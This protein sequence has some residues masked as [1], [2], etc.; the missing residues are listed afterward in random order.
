MFVIIGVAMSVPVL[1]DHNTW[2]NALECSLV[3][4]TE[5]AEDHWLIDEHIVLN[6]HE[7]QKYACARQNRAAV[8]LPRYSNKQV[9]GDFKS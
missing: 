5:E 8:A 2:G 4:A 6:M 9:V 1:T 3:S 7:Q